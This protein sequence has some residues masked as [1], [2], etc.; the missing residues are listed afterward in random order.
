ME[1]IRLLD[2]SI[3]ASPLTPDRVRLTGSIE[4]DLVKREFWFDV[5]K[6]Y[7]EYLSKSGNVWLVTMLPFAIKTGAAIEMNLSID[8]E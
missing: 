6:K 3:G 8:L 2:T 5:P 1:Y 7:K 4:F